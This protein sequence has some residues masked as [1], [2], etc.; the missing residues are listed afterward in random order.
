MKKWEHIFLEAPRPNYIAKHKWLGRLL[1]YVGVPVIV[2]VLYAIFSG[3]LALADGRE[4]LS[5]LT[6]VAYEVFLILLPIV[7]LLLMR[8]SPLR[9]PVDPFAAAEL[10]LL[11]LIC[12]T[13]RG[14]IRTGSLSRAF[15]EVRLDFGDDGNLM[16]FVLGAAFVFALLCSIS[17]ARVKGNS[18]YYRHIERN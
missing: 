12:F 18:F 5:W 4:D 17:K 9:W 6:L 1:Y 14:W 3:L 16:W 13:V 7:T 2:S 15:A 10:P 8:C 11:I